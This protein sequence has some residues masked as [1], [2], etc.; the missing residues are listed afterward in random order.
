[1]DRKT[2]SPT[3]T[4][5]VG[6]CSQIIGLPS[7]FVVEE[8]TYNPVNQQKD[9]TIQAVFLSL[10]SAFCSKYETESSNFLSPVKHAYSKCT[11]FSLE[12][13]S[14]ILGIMIF[15]TIEQSFSTGKTIGRRFSTW[16]QMPLLLDWISSLLICIIV[17]SNNQARIVF[18]T[19]WSFSFV[20]H[21][22]TIL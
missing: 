17:A 4:K 8:S 20:G 3:I 10:Y 6:Y 14:L 16:F 13:I 21:N 18:V 12:Q 11:F 7:N 1:M 9:L 2:Q 19:Q 15:I 5:D 22:P